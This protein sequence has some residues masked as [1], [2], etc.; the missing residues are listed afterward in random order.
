MRDVEDT[1]KTGESASQLTSRWS[2]D[3][4]VLPSF[5]SPR[6]RS[7]WSLCHTAKF[8]RQ[9]ISVKRLRSYVIRVWC[10]SWQS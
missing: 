2:G 1:E 4:K 9:T 8:I 5:Q 6:R 7:T 3:L 10:F